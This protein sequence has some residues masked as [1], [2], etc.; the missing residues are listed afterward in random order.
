MVA[1]ISHRPFFVAPAPEPV[2][3]LTRDSAAAAITTAPVRQSRAA[4]HHRQL[5]LSQEDFSVPVGLIEN[6]LLELFDS[7]SKRIAKRLFGDAAQRTLF[8]F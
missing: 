6:V 8:E 4:R 7:D 5:A 1:P 2:G 3:L